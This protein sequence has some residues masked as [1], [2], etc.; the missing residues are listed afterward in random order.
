V[1][2][3]RDSH[4]Y[5]G[6]NLELRVGSRVLIRSAHVIFPLSGSVFM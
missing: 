5:G 4:N 6:S 2:L 3:D 1:I